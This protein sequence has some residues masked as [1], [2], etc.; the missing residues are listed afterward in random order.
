M[1]KVYDS[2][3][4]KT[5][6]LVNLKSK[7]FEWPANQVFFNVPICLSSEL[8]KFLLGEISQFNTESKTFHSF[9]INRAFKK[10]KFLLILEYVSLC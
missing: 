2:L 8:Y 5:L 10:K 1:D 3:N 7:I 4:S 9:S 6:S